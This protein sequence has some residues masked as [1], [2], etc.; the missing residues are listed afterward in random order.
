MQKEQQ[1]LGVTCEV[2]GKTYKG[3]YWIAGKILVVSTSKGG[4]SRQVGSFPAET[5]AR[6]LL[7]ELVKA[8]KA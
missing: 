7:E 5:L 2:D 4:K 1:H 3:N 6:Q 8:G